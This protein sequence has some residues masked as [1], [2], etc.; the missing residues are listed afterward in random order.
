M[1]HKHIT[2]ATRNVPGYNA[3]QPAASRKGGG[4]PHKQ[5]SLVVPHFKNADKKGGKK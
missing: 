4:Y 2:F 1:K 5:P 3:P